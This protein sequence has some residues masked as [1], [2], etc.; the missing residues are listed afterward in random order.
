MKTWRLFQMRELTY[1]EA[2]L[3][4][5]HFLGELYDVLQKAEAPDYDWPNGAEGNSVIAYLH[6]IFHNELSSNTIKF[7]K[8]KARL[9]EVFCLEFD[10]WCD[11]AL[12]TASTVGVLNE[13]QSVREQSHPD[14]Y[15]YITFVVYWTENPGV[16]IIRRNVPKGTY[17]TIGEIQELS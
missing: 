3:L 12:E 8:S 15:H 6:A 17:E 11:E 13:Y 7:D 2:S 10:E 1:F 16:A 4:R 9:K 5:V 14:W